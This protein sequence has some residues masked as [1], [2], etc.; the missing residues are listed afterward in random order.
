MN[1]NPQYRPKQ[2]VSSNA[3]A[4]DVMDITIRILEEN[5]IR[6]DLTSNEFEAFQ[7]IKDILE[8]TAKKAHV[9]DLIKEKR[10]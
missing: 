10:I 4:V 3:S 1:I 5:F 9:F 7:H 6:S 2:F 8:N